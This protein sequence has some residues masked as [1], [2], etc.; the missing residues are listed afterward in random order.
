MRDDGGSKEGCILRVYVNVA[1]SKKTVWKGLL[2]LIHLLI[3][4]TC[5]VL[6]H[7]WCCAHLNYVGM[8]CFLLFSQCTVI[9]LA[10]HDTLYFHR[11]ASVWWVRFI[12]RKATATFISESNDCEIVM[13]ICLFFW[14]VWHSANNWANYLIICW[15]L[16]SGKCT[17]DFFFF[18]FFGA[19][20]VNC[21]LLNIGLPAC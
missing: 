10:T 8:L 21:G 18:F 7:M 15:D 17:S 9:W 5:C 1:F 4:P 19:P 2:L 12:T 16:Q 13:L 6:L 3:S 20:G 14:C 11:I